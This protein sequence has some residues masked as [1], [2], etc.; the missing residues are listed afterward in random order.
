MEF[1]LN[2]SDN[3][4]RQ[5]WKKALKRRERHQLQRKMH[6]KKKTS[7]INLLIKVENAMIR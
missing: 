7:K 3:K 1:T 2:L 5:M 6:Y 4:K